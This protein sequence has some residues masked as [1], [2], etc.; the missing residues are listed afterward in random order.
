MRKLIVLG[1]GT[2][3]AAGATVS[4]LLFGAGMASA[5]PDVVGQTYSDAAQAIEWSG[6]SP[7]VAVAVGSRLSQDDCIVTNVWDAPFVRDIGGG[8]F[9]HSSG[10]VMLSLN[11]DGGHATATNP[12]A[13]VASPVGRESKAAADEAAAAEQEQL[14]AVSTPDE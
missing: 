8:E 6:G 9:G 12:G 2:A 14:E 13:S 10:E 7:K 1:A 4:S 5:A 3:V 11:C